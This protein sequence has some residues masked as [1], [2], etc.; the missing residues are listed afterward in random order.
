VGYTRGKESDVM[1]DKRR[2]VEGASDKW[3]VETAESELFGI[4]LN[5]RSS[6]LS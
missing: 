1:D 3:R 5:S 4:K 6:A 2:V